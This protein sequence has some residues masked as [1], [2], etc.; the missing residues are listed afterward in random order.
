[1]KKPTAGSQQQNTGTTDRLETPT[2]TLIVDDSKGVRE[3]ILNILTNVGYESVGSG[4]G[5]LALLESGERFD[6]M[7]CGLL[8][9]PHGINL[10]DRSKK[11]Y[12]T[13]PVIISTA[14]CCLYTAQ[15]AVNNMGASGFLVKPFPVKVLLMAIWRTLSGRSVV[16][17]NG[18][19]HS[20]FSRPITHDRVE[21][22]VKQKVA[23]VGGEQEDRP[24]VVRVECAPEEAPEIGDYL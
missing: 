24:V 5:A 10:L 19:E 9:N 21:G 22:T 7:L 20:A 2:P 1:M 12:P 3:L 4:R 14:P 8:N 6:L 11:V 15:F 18:G 17:A 23:Y 13:M 16:H